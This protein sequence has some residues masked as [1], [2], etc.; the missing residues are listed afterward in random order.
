MM[1]EDHGLARRKEGFSSMSATSLPLDGVRALEKSG[2]LAGRLAG[3]LLADQG[4]AV[5]ALD[6][7]GSGEEDVDH[8]LNRGKNLVPARVLAADE[9]AD[10]LIEIGRAHV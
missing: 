8:Y 2:A 9:N 7:D 10:I 3:L 6:R 4:A 5:F 1:Q